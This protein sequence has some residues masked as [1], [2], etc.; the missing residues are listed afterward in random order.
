[1]DIGL[2]RELQKHKDKGTRLQ[3]ETSRPVNTRINHMSAG[4]CKTISNR[5][6][7]TLTPSEPSSST[8]TSPGYT[9]TPKNQE[10]DIKSYLM[11]IIESFKGSLNNSLKEMQENTFYGTV[12]LVLVAVADS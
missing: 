3:R 7:Y 5:S 12:C 6:Q 1:M 9:N 8:T 10:P 4:K 11:K 2:P